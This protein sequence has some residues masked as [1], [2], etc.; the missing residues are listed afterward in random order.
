MYSTALQ[1]WGPSIERVCSAPGIDR[2][3]TRQIPRAH[4]PATRAETVNFKVQW[5]S[6][7]GIKSDRGRPQCPPQTS[8][9]S[10]RYEK[11][12]WNTNLAMQMTCPWQL[13]QLQ[14]LC[15]WTYVLGGSTRSSLVPTAVFTLLWSSACIAFVHG[16]SP[17]CLY[18][19][20]PCHSALETQ[21]S[22]WVSQLCHCSSILCIELTMGYL[23]QW[24]S[25]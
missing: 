15:P 25:G 2:G 23:E 19:L 24:N 10:H 14:P 4:L 13:A 18:H 17:G 20:Y 12:S 16:P 1:V 21:H 9:M 7:S 8:C 3:R 11:K 22:L 6:V 5:V